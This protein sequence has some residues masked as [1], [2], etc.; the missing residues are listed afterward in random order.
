MK[1]IDCSHGAA[2]LS[3]RNESPCLLDRRL[4]W[5]QGRLGLLQNRKI[6]FVL[7]NEPQLRSFSPQF[8]HYEIECSL[9]C[10]KQPTNCPY[11]EDGYSILRTLI[12]LRFILILF[13]PTSR[14]SNS[15]VSF[16]FLHQ[17]PTRTS[18]LPYGCL[19]LW[20]IYLRFDYPNAV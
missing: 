3:Q 13:L 17:N 8:C 18:P 6:P 5:L 10:L 16:R 7:G 15:F 4:R 1:L 2:V 11:P 9:L 19:M 20:Q 12:A 14:P